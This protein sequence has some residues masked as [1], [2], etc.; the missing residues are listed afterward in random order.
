MLMA[1]AA[2]LQD[3]AKPTRAAIESHMARNLCR[4][5][6]HTRIVDA[7]EAVAQAPAPAA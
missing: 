5:G 6:A 7:I 2:F 1:A 3:N 4:C